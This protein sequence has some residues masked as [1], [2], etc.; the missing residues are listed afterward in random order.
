[1]NIWKIRSVWSEEIVR[2]KTVK[3]AIAIYESQNLSEVTKEDKAIIS[4][5]LIGDTFN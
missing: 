2:A 3:E 1:M 5:E 4:A